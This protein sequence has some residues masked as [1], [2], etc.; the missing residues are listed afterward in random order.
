MAAN[1]SSFQHHEQKNLAAEI[2]NNIPIMTLKKMAQR[3]SNVENKLF[4]F[5]SQRKW[6]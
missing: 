5:I 6:G 3:Q 1:I 4:S 2:A